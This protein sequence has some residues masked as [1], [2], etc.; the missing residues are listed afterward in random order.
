[1]MEYYSTIKNNETLSFMTIQMGLEGIVLSKVSQTDENKYH[2]IS[3]ICGFPKGM[4][5]DTENRLVVVSG[6]GKSGNKE[7]KRYN[8][9]VIK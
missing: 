9:P 1:M 8:F 4:F 5:M 3:L 2:M 6:R 7:A